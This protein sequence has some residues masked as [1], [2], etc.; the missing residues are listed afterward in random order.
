MLGDQ[1]AGEGL[2]YPSTV[3]Y[4]T[5]G[6]E[7]VCEGGRFPPT[8]GEGCHEGWGFPPMGGEGSMRDAIPTYS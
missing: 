4:L 1:S 3:G 5:T 8:R 2:L 7:G 6:G